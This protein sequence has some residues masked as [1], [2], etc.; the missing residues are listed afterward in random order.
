M[1]RSGKHDFKNDLDSQIA[2]VPIILTSSWGLGE[3][4]K[5]SDTLIWGTISLLIFPSTTS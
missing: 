2:L 4:G 3:T 1:F 5:V